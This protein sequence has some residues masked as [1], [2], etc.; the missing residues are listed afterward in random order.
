MRK[1]QQNTVPPEFDSLYRPV[2]KVKQVITNKNKEFDITE[3]LEGVALLHYCTFILGRIGKINHKADNNIILVRQLVEDILDG[4]QFLLL[5]EHISQLSSFIDKVAREL[6]LNSKSVVYVA[7]YEAYLDSWLYK[8]F[9]SHLGI[10]K[11]DGFDYVAPETVANLKI[12]HDQ[13]VQY[14]VK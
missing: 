3:V 1:S 9:N 4:N 12:L 11:F 6:N 5:N 8:Y 10:Y 14:V 7:F 2:L 13:H